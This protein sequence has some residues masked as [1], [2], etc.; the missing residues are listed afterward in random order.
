VA[1]KR[2]AEKGE[3][4]DVMKTLCFVIKLLEM[5]LKRGIEDVINGI[6]AQTVCC[7]CVIF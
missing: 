4:A 6:K 7:L 5:P 2:G 3:G 1:K